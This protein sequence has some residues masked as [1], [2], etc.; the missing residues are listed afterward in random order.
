MRPQNALIQIDRFDS[1]GLTR[2]SL[3]SLVIPP[4]GRDVTLPCALAVYLYSKYLHRMYCK[5]F[6]RS[7]RAC[8]VSNWRLNLSLDPD[9]PDHLLVGILDCYS[10]L[11]LLRFPLRVTWQLERC[12]VFFFFFAVQAHPRGFLALNGEGDVGTARHGGGLERLVGAIA[13]TFI[14]CR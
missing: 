7:T 9:R 12:G 14:L 6:S 2:R 8:K 11:L 1:Q 10:S 5:A 3:L 4:G 13:L